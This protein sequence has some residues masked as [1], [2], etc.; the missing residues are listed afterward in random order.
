MFKR[1]SIGLLALV[2][3]LQ[4]LD[5]DPQVQKILERHE[6]AKP[7]EQSLA[8]YGLDWAPTL[9][10][11]KARAKKEGRPIFFIWLTNISAAT[12]FFTG[13]C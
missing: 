8:F 12:S 13:H 10:E 3:T 11:A 2:G 5:Q 1:V 6:A 9:Q 7:T 4:A